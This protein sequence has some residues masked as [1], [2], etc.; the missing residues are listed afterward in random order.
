[1]AQSLLNILVN[2]RIFVF[3]KMIELEIPESITDFIQ[4]RVPRRVGAKHYI[5]LAR[6]PSKY[7]PRYVGY[8]ENLRN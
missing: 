1:M 2:V 6:Q 4:E 7:Y 3:D 8:I 5:D